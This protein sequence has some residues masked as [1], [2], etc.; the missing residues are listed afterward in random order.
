MGYHYE[1]MTNARGGLAPDSARVAIRDDQE[2]SEQVPLMRTRSGHDLVSA[3]VETGQ[4]LPKRCTR[5]GGR[6]P[7]D[8]RVC[9]RDA[10]PL[11]DAP[12]GADPM[13]GVC[14]NGTYEIVRMIGEGGMG[15]VYEARHARL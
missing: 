3:E 14:L 1:L 7:A 8:F 9:P 5:C 10:I 2:N 13:L 12:E 15:R 6:Y 4:R 11:E